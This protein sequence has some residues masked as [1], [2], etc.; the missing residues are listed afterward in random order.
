MG[1]AQHSQFKLKNSLA[2]IFQRDCTHLFKSG[3]YAI[4]IALT[5]AKLPKGSTVI[6]PAICC[7]AV[8]SAI[9]MAGYVP[10]IADVCE[11]SYCMEIDN[12]K[13]IFDQNCSAVIAV[14]AYG[15]PCGIKKIKEFCDKKG[16]FLIEDACLGYGFSDQSGMLGRVG[17]VSVISFGY[18][19]PLDCGGGGALL[20]NNESLS[21]RI[22]YF[23]G[24]NPFFMMDQKHQELACQNICYLPTNIEKRIKNT[25]LYLSLIDP[26]NVIL[27]DNNFAY[28]RLPIV[29]KNKRD[30]LVDEVNKHG[31]VITKHYR[32]LGGMA[33]N[34]FTPK[35]DKIDKTIIN[36]F[37]RPSTS[38]EYIHSVSGLINSFYN[39]V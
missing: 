30:E 4:I 16:L 23:L 3:S 1:I 20:T 28:W 38:S 13:E 5:A 8:L 19:K 15:R 18:D 31:Y 29:V 35:A 22:D 39:G 37:T 2:D 27:P 11:K 10:A 21:T 26:K 6:M 17:D 33:T 12:L 24:E 7:P 25:N 36:L 9:Q 14:H 34:S 32:S